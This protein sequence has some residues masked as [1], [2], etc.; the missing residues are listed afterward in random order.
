MEVMD[1]TNQ[2]TIR[3]HGVWKPLQVFPSSGHI[4]MPQDSLDLVSSPNI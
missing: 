1:E 3:A 4:L 2:G